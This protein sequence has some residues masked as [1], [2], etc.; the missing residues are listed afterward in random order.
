MQRLEVSSAVRP[1]YGSLGVKRLNETQ[2]AGTS[3]TTKIPCPL[4]IAQHCADCSFLKHNNSQTRPDLSKGSVPQNLYV[5][6]ILP[7]SE[8]EPLPTKHTHTCLY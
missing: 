5:K 2:Q 3:G 8:F 7:M 6:E 1:I 4:Y